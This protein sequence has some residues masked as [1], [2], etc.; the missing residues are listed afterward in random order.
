MNVT[1]PKVSIFFL[2]FLPQ[3]ADPSRGS[4]PIQLVILGAVFIFATILVFGSIALLAGAIGHWFN[5][6]G[7]AQ[8]IMNCLCRTRAE[9]GADRAVKRKNSS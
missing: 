7:K 1:N 3:F 5:R 9:A 2:A 8:L 4:L 6:S